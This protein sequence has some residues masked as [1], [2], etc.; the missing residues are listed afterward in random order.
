MTVMN[1]AA[2][3]RKA[4][5]GEKRTKQTV[6]C[7]ERVSPHQDSCWSW[8]VCLVAVLSNVVICGFAFSFGILFPALL[9][10]FQQ[11]KAKTGI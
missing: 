5:D 3:V 4:T 6:I 8:M 1:K 11:G 9:D 7:I 10:E 2:E